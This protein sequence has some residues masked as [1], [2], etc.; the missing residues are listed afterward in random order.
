MKSL[1]YNLTEFSVWHCGYFQNR[2]KLSK[3][4]KKKKKK[5]NLQNLEILENLVQ[6]IIDAFRLILRYSRGWK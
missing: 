3:E 4:K 2:Q 6:Y 5:K 1:V